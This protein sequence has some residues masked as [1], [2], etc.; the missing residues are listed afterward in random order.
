MAVQFASHGTWDRQIRLTHCPMELTYAYVM[1]RKSF[2]LKLG[3]RTP[4]SR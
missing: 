1:H 3:M 4:P 2:G